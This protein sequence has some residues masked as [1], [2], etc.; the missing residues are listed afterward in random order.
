MPRHRSW[1]CVALWSATLIAPLSA[2]DA[3]HD[4]D[5]RRLAERSDVREAFRIIERIDPASRDDLIAL[6]QIPAPPVPTRCGS[7]RWATS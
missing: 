1:C 5:L 4:A 6:T 3:R 7:M 2:Q